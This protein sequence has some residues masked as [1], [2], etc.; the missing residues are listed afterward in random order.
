MSSL[1]FWS[2]W[3]RSENIGAQGLLKEKVNPVC[4][5]L[6]GE[7]PIQASSMDHEDTMVSP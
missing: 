2:L 1:P 3:L 6:H 5:L 4:T 7:K